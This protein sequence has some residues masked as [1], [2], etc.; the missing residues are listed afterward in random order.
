[1]C[2][3]VAAAWMGALPPSGGPTGLTHALLPACHSVFHWQLLPT[4]EPH[5]KSSLSLSTRL[6][7]QPATAL[8]RCSPSGNE[9]GEGIIKVKGKLAWGMNTGRSGAPGKGGG[10]QQHMS[11]LSVTEPSS[12]LST[13]LSA[14]SYP[15]PPAV[16]P[17]FCYFTSLCLSI[18]I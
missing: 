12:E 15:M 4:P 8:L 2:G 9:V 10:S 16:R 5:R 1:M 11:E 14:F 13:V 3:V 6:W 17:P 18:L 7:P